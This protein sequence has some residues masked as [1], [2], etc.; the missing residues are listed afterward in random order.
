MPAPAKKCASK[1][2]ISQNMALYPLLNASCAAS[3]PFLCS[4]MEIMAESATGAWQILQ[5][6]HDAWPEERCSAYK[7][8]EILWWLED[9]ISEKDKGVCSWMG[10]GRECNACQRWREEICAVSGAL[11]LVVLRKEKLACRGSKTWMDVVVHA[12]SSCS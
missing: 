2:Y 6:W 8:N 3:R 9:K 10:P 5:C 12:F 4:K 11:G 1:W 7:K